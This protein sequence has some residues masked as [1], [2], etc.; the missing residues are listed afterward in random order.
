MNNLTPILTIIVPSYNTSKYVDECLPSFISNQ[1]INKVKIILI[2]DG[3]TDD[4]ATKIGK[5]TQKYPDLF[6]FVHKDNGGHGSVINYGVHKIVL[7]KYFKIIDGDDWSDSSTLLEFVS[8]LEQ[9][10]YDLVINDFVKVYHSK[11]EYQKCYGV[12]DYGHYRGFY[13]TIHSMTFKTSIFKNNSI[14]VREK[15]FYEDN[16]FVLFPLEYVNTIGYFNKPIYYYRLG[17]TNQSVS[18][19]SMLKRRND[20]ILV[21]N[22]ILSKY[23]SWKDRLKNESL[24]KYSQY[25]LTCFYSWAFE[26][27]LLVDGRKNDFLQLIAELDQVPEIKQNMHKKKSFK[28]ISS[29]GFSFLKLK[30]KILKKRLHI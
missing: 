12:E 26:S 27:L 10:D 22:D 29:F 25:S 19:Q 14:F 21:K 3:A 17:N 4:T 28:F 2:D 24:I 18:V 13:T 16:E 11:Q 30:K 15:V 9:N 7:T 23:L 5:Y 6:S 8:F 1:L 20:Y